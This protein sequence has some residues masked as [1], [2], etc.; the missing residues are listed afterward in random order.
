MSQLFEVDIG[1]ISGNFIKWWS[2]PSE[3]VEAV[4]YA[5]K[6]IGKE[7]LNIKMVSVCHL[8]L[9]FANKQ[10]GINPFELEESCLKYFNHTEEDIVRLLEI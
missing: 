5:S 1:L 10:D 4:I 3:F 8:A 6:P 7:F 9:Y 2:L